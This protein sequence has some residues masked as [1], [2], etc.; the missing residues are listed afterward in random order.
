[1]FFNILPQN[2]FEHICIG[3]SLRKQ[4]LFAKLGNRICFNSKDLFYDLCGLGLIKGG[5][6]IIAYFRNNIFLKTT[7]RLE[8]RNQMTM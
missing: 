2:R 6:K 1:M 8:G 7:H 5:N 4:R 3:H